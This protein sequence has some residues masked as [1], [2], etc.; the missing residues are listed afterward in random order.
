MDTT[1]A[2]YAEAELEQVAHCF[3]HW[4]RHRINRTGP[5]PP[6]LWQQAASIAARLPVG[7]VAKRLGVKSATL[8]QHAMHHCAD[9][10]PVATPHA[11]L[12]RLDFVEVPPAPMGLPP[13]GVTQIELSRADGTRLCMQTPIAPLP[14]EALV[15]AFVEGRSCSN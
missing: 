9:R 15:R 3:A 5:L 13:V 4:R 8:K 12:P 2:A 11:P 7:R 10:P 14:L 1:P 6:V